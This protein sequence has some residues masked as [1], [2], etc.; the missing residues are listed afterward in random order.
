MTVDSAQEVRQ[1]MHVAPSLPTQQSM[2]ARMATAVNLIAI[3]AGCSRRRAWMT[4]LWIWSLVW[5]ARRH[6]YA[7]RRMTMVTQWVFPY[8]QFDVVIPHD[9]VAAPG[10]AHQAIE[11]ALLNHQRG[12]LN[13]RHE[14]NGYCA[15]RL[16]TGR[17][18]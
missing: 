16:L 3:E 17:Y 12:E 11:N 10:S 18:Q 6:D 5:Q 15:F 13:I 8:R 9:S 14:N 7:E 1:E 2:Y 4:L